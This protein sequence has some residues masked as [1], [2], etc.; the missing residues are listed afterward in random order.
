MGHHIGKRR[1]ETLAH[2]VIPLMGIF[3]EDTGGRHH[4]QS[5]VNKTD[6]KLNVGDV[7]QLVYQESTEKRS[8]V[9]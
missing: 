4:V 3:K 9:L 7:E 2:A 6:S 1:E 8:C 5:V